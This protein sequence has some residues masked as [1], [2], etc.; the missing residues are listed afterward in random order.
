MPSNP[1]DGYHTVTAQSIT[2]D[3]AETIAF[4][5]SVFG[6]TSYDRYIVDDVIVH[7]EVQ[8]GDSRVMLG[9]S[10]DEFPAYHLC[11]HV[12][13]EDVDATYARALEHGASGVREPEDQFYGD[14]SAVVTD[15]QG[16]MWSIATRVED[17]S[18]EEIRRRM[19]EMA[20]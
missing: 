20:D 8:V 4:L 9:T 1:P 10:N 19:A 12:Y 15:K 18:S 6:A 3:P 7:A 17:V 16:N 11:S 5:E 13:V 14:R 2:A